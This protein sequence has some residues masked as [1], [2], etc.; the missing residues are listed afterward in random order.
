MSNWVEKKLQINVN[1]AGENLWR[2]KDSSWKFLDELLLFQCQ[3]SMGNFCRKFSKSQR[4]V[5]LQE[6]NNFSS[7]FPVFSSARVTKSQFK[8]R[9]KTLS[10]ARR[11][12]VTMNKI[13]LIIQNQ[14]WSMQS[15]EIFQISQSRF[16]GRF[17]SSCREFSIFLSSRISIAVISRSIRLCGRDSKWTQFSV[18]YV[19]LMKKRSRELLLFDR[20]NFA[21][22]QFLRTSFFVES[23]RG[24]PFQIVLFVDL[25]FRSAINKKK[26]WFN[27][28]VW[29]LLELT[30]MAFLAFIREE[31][32]FKRIK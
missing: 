11:A 26:I 13:K 19:Y 27:K 29:A 9:K 20:I 1:V 18:I 23:R 31:S 17:S 6:F 12:S 10:T 3:H 32:W 28:T 14:D 5:S 15:A 21:R 22:W 4:N 24:E 8:N 2:M 25:N 30:L 7:S 16:S